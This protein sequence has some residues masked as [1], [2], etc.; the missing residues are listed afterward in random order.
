MPWDM[1]R[2]RNWIAVAKVHVLVER[3]M[4]AGLAPLL[5]KLPHD[6]ILSNVDRFSGLTR[7]ELAETTCWWAAPTCR[8]CCPSLSGGGW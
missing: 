1:P 2:F 5:F 7:Q 8:C 6:D 4:A 3:A